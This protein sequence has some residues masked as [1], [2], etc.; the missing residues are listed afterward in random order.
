[1]RLQGPGSCGV[2]RQDRGA[3]ELT[4]RA[5]AAR[6]TG[7]AGRTGLS[8]LASRAC[9]G[10][11]D[12]GAEP[13]ALRQDRLTTAT[14]RFFIQHRTCEGPSPAARPTR[15]S[16]AC[17][18]S[19]QASGRTAVFC[20]QPSPR[21]SNTSVSAPRRASPAVPD[22]AWWVPDSAC[23]ELSAEWPQCNASNANST[24][25]EFAVDATKT[26]RGPKEA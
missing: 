22:S 11:R 4:E 23:F 21:C 12:Q 5:P 20:L 9:K 3:V 6:S 18:P 26:L 1:V 16:A 15:Q 17:C 19:L 14:A 2:L 13:A 25:V 7:D 24:T 10:R 8:G